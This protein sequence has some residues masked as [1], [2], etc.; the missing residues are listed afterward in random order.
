MP[1]DNLTKQFQEQLRQMRKGSGITNVTPSPP[2]SI[3]QQPSM[4]NQQGQR[5]SDVIGG[6]QQPSWG[7]QPDESGNLL[8]ATAKGLWTAAET[9]LFG[10]PRLFLPESAK[11]WL[12]PKSFGER[13]A[14]GVGG[15]AGFL[16][17]MRWGAAA[18]SKG[19]QVFAK[20]GVKRFAGRYVDDSIKLMEK[21]K[22]FVKWIE[23]KIARGEIEEA[24]VTDFMKRILSEPKSNILALGTKEGQ[25]LM[26]RGV[27]DKTSF[28][29]SFQENTPKILME[30]LDEAGFRGLNAQKIVD[31]LGDDILKK[32]GSVSTD[33]S[34]VFKFPMT[35]LH[36]V[37]GGWT[38]NG[39]L[40]NI[41]AHAVEESILFAAIET[42]MAAIRAQADDQMDEFSLKGTLAHAFI[43]GSAL[44]IIRPAVKGFGEGGK[45]Q[46]I[47]RT[48]LS[49]ITNTVK[50]RRK[51]RNYELEVDKTRGIGAEIVEAD[52][53]RFIDEVKLVWGNNKD[54]FKDVRKIK[55]KS[56]EAAIDKDYGIPLKKKGDLDELMGTVEGRAQLKRVMMDTEKAFFDNWYPKFLKEIPQDLWESSPRMM[57]GALAFNYE[58]YMEWFDKGYPLEDIIFHTALGMFM[59]KRGKALEYTS[60]GK[61]KTLY[62]ERPYVYS[63]D[64]KK[65]DR[66]L[67]ALGS[68]LDASL[69]RAVFNET[70][71]IKRGFSDVDPNSKD[72]QELKAIAERHGIILDR[73]VGTDDAGNNIER[74][75]KAGKTGLKVED[76]ATGKK[77]AEERQVDFDDDV[78]SAFAG[79]VKK[80]FLSKATETEQDV[81]E[82][83]EINE[84][85]LRKIKKDLREYQFD[86]LKEFAVEKGKAGI[87]KGTDV[88]DVVLG[89]AET[90]A[91][92]YRDIIQRAVIDMYN[93]VL[94]LESPDTW[95]PIEYDWS[96][97]ETKLVL[98]PFSMSSKINTPSWAYSR[99]MLGEDSNLFL[100]LRPFVQFRGKP[101]DLSQE[102]VDKVYGTWSEGRRDQSKT[103]IMD[104]YHREVNE[105]IFGESL[106]QIPMERWLL[107]G[108][109]MIQNWTSLVLNRRSIRKHW[110]V[111]E[112]LSP[113][114]KNELGLF[115]DTQYGEVKQLIS[116]V[117]EE[118]GYLANSIEMVSGRG[119]KLDYSKD[120]ASDYNFLK[121]LLKVLQGDV[122]RAQTGWIGGESPP[123]KKAF[124]NDITK[125]KNILTDKMP[126]LTMSTRDSAERIAKD[127]LI[128]QLYEYTVDKTLGL[129]TKA[130][131]RYLDSTDR[132]KIR[133]LQHSGILSPK[134][135]MM[136]ISG[137]VNDFGKLFT[138]FQNK[139][140]KKAAEMDDMADFMRYL[141]AKDSNV[142]ID[143]VGE[144][145]DFRFFSELTAAAKSQGQSVAEFSKTL[146][147]NFQKH[148]EPYTRGS[149]GNGFIQ[150]GKYRATVDPGYLGQL[151]S[152]LDLL[153]QDVARVSH[154]EL[155]NDIIPNIG[156]KWT[157]DKDIDN[158]INALLTK[159]FN[160]V[161]SNPSRAGVATQILARAG[162]YNKSERFW[163]WDE[164]TKEPEK[165]QDIIKNIEA[166]LNLDFQVFKTTADLEKIHHR[167]R[168]DNESVYPA[169]KP[170]TMNL[171]GFVKKYRISN[172]SGSSGKTLSRVLRDTP[173]VMKNAWSFYKHLKKEGAVL[174]H[175]KNQYT[176][177]QWMDNP[178]LNDAH[179]D[180]LLDSI[181][182]YNQLRNAKTR[183]LITVTH[184]QKNPRWEEFTYQDNEVFKA[185]EDIL[186]ELTLINTAGYKRK[187]DGRISTFDIRRGNVDPAFEADFYNSLG[188]QPAAFR[189]G[190]ATPRDMIEDI[191]SAHLNQPFIVAYISTLGNGI[192]I[193]IGSMSSRSQR[194]TYAMNNLA[195]KFVDVYSKVRKDLPTEAKTEFDDFIKKV[196]IDT[197]A[198]EGKPMNLKSDGWEY[199]NIASYSKMS[200]DFTVML[201]N[202][203]GDRVMGK[204]FWDAAKGDN[205]GN[206][207]GL[208]K[209]QLRY[210]KILFNRSAKRLD[211]KHITDLI[212]VLEKPEMEFID[213]SIRGDQK[214]SIKKELYRLTKEGT[215]TH[216][217]E[218]ESVI[219]GGELPNASSLF[220][221]LNNQIMAEEAEMHKTD[222][223]F[224]LNDM[225]DPKSFPGGIKDGNM[226]DSINIV[227][228]EYMRV[229]RF[230]SGISNND[231][232]TVKPIGG[233]GSSKDAVWID[234]TVWITDAAWEPYFKNNKVDMVKMGSSVKMAGEKHMGVKDANGRY[235][236]AIYLDETDSN[237]NLVY[238]NM[239]AVM[240]ATIGKDKVINL[241]METFGISSFVKSSKNATIPIQL[242]NDL[243]TEALNSSFFDWMFRA[244]LRSFIEESG[245]SYGAGDIASIGSKLRYEDI[246]TSSDQLSLLDMWIQEGLDPTY[247]VFKR[248]V[249]NAVKRQ[250]LD[251]RGVFT[252][253]NPHGS[254]SN[255]VPTWAD[256]GAVNSLRFTTFRSREID[257]SI[258]R[259]IWTYGQIEIDNVNRGKLV[260]QER[261]RFIEHNNAAKDNIVNTK[262]LGSKEIETL[263]DGKKTVTIGELHDALTEYNKKLDGK[264]YEVA[265][266]AHRTPTTRASDKV[267]VGLKG[268]DLTGNSVRINH[269]DA[270]IRLEAD[271]DLDKLN[272]WWDTPS[273]I[274][275]HWDKISGQVD[276]I[277][278]VQTRRTV[279]G[280]KLSDGESLIRYNRSERDS[281][282][283]RG[284][285]V[286]SRRMVQF[287][288]NYRNARFADVDGFS[289]KLQQGAGRLSIAG[290]K[291][292]EAVEK[293]IAED[294]QRVVDAQG[295]GMDD[296]IFNDGW[297]DRILFG[298]GTD[299]YP[300]LILKQSYDANKKIYMGELPLSGLEKD[301]VKLVLRPYQRL[302]QL[303]TSV[304]ENGESKKVDYDS[305]IDYV[306]IYRKQMDNLN[307]HIYY[308]LIN[309]KTPSGKSYDKTRIDG[310]FKRNKE[311]VDPF[312]LD[313]AKFGETREGIDI[314]ES[315]RTMIAGDRMLGVVG[316]HDRLRMPKIDYETQVATDDIMMDLLT[317]N[318][319]D[320]TSATKMIYEQYKSD[321]KK[322]SALNSIDYRIR[323][324]RD[325]AHTAFKNGSTGLYN[326]WH[327]RAGSLE[328]FRNDL[329]TQIM[330]SSKTQRVIRNRIRSQIKTQLLSGKTWTAYNG[331]EYNLSSQKMRQREISIG[332]LSKTIERS[333]WDYRN[334][335]LGVTVRGVNGDDYLQTLVTYNVLS[336]ITG[337][338]L[339]PELVGIDK[340][341]EWETDRADMRRNYGKQFRDYRNG[342]V[343]AGKD[344]DDIMN[345]AL[346]D[347]EG[348]YHKWDAES[349]GLGK[350]FVFSVMTPQ[351]DATT[352][353]YHK[354]YLMPGFKQTSSQAKF[355]NLGLRFFSRIDSDMARQ[356]IRMIG[357]PISEQLA[358]FRNGSLS[359]PMLGENFMTEANIRKR[360][361]VDFDVN[362]GGSPLIEYGSDTTKKEM[363]NKMMA[364]SDQDYY[365]VLDSKELD[366]TNMNENMLR[367][368]GLSGDVALDYIAFRAPALGMEMIG[369]IRLIADMSFIPSN[370]I[371]RSGSVVPIGD[372]NAYMRHK[373]NQAFMFFGDMS[374]QK[375][376]FTAQKTVVGSDVYG[377]PEYDKTARDYMKT[378]SERWLNES[379]PKKEGWK[380]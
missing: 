179:Y 291:Q 303:Q 90:S 29:K 228:K 89:S 142:L 147:D 364:H 164:Y 298:D 278:G 151:V 51:W 24:T 35:R 294:I 229:I 266:V 360:N 127:T 47:F 133:V 108:D 25:A 71:M 17:P 220:R 363:M 22:D 338:G 371:T 138:H 84:S 190:A 15:A 140:P 1:Q 362:E 287:L 132:A 312:N 359:A 210:M 87:T 301:I 167:D 97:E 39:R 192:G 74:T 143:L 259:D 370:A 135:D 104:K 99:A 260:N 198:V 59:T 349:P 183:R 337:A 377:T 63:D 353:T 36:Q 41:A 379:E 239:E 221:K 254:Q 178:K 212:D 273:D 33:T 66:Y 46:P 282:F 81:L 130:D 227:S 293:Q 244:N 184:G 331:K 166:Q 165:L 44:G 322:I 199:G 351:M 193:P 115:T 111:L 286:K 98:R 57:L 49:R 128:D 346:A 225:Q 368:I 131:G 103:A 335:K 23:K 95:K 347:M 283:H 310:I 83:W 234:K 2:T 263:L 240:G 91:V 156:K 43:L 75:K 246:E 60:G 107:A 189:K 323:R 160:T 163:T 321:V 191:G 40:G 155:M 325:N 159:V 10:V 174:T 7:V 330:S 118:G 251:R 376:I 211:K 5:L 374:N 175:N 319:K 317:G 299:K 105:L 69:Y 6:G 181:S 271:H 4:M 16:F 21:D 32:I 305:L 296:Q 12:E 30:K 168:L 26:A 80:N 82:T 306:Q 137:F 62:K 316:S 56:K 232:E 55:R 300:G 247:Y 122:K 272:Y 152:R 248:S 106:E 365:K 38:G 217:I 235:P 113:D 216:Y 125:L 121:S 8:T 357:K 242:G 257:G 42:P 94:R 45:D 180:F 145:N 100:L 345:E 154:K 146:M 34:K 324:Y 139:H 144:V 255:M 120:T 110:R 237:N 262:G 219:D 253:T 269:A 226:F 339:N 215:R 258:Q 372:F 375:N 313:D 119:K 297:M 366:F 241:P 153:N 329:Q 355:V 290:D 3:T 64:L 67:Q 96:T 58:T 109:S 141:S 309:G 334:K 177:E 333:I 112:D 93:E 79:V 361:P 289:M 213:N 295:R 348:F 101:I 65:T 116:K 275:N 194:K 222:K 308:N 205:W 206:S 136:D 307:K 86:G 197:K 284:T 265:I 70:E 124:R 276:S 315:N 88:L 328:S 326:Y 170:V 203:V 250:L 267:I 304:Y 13:A 11:E 249:K 207:E 134:F 18:L 72:M 172:L 186:G 343:D 37:I 195:Q 223:G 52:R 202:T 204:E 196:L 20:H 53:A 367:T 209:K 245:K 350:Y 277:S 233:L 256:Y 182:I 185:I 311:F 61:L 238:E 161:H 157:A 358:Y 92:A 320:V 102:M 149:D 280:L 208:A 73:F 369:D 373:R 279:E 78:Y 318:L 76:P 126:L 27:K 327:D 54:I 342:R 68:N 129:V 218:D 31:T 252:P 201:T 264:S 77:V 378:Q 243:T 292:V 173:K 336:N 200:R 270:W 285:V 231:I 117:F 85:T 158:N 150:V 230:L 344:I 302:L 123:P 274:L 341:R 171:S 340:A 380:C 48:A 114:A 356:A 224:K 28:V 352:V 188:S 169:D 354:G 236:K 176:S 261:I 9:T 281:Q 19:V 187:V 288:K 14:V 268:F 162:I 50:N 214:G 148:I 314:L 332:N